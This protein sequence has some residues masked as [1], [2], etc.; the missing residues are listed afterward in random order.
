M[1]KIVIFKFDV[2]ISL[3][4]KSVICFFI[5]LRIIV[6]QNNIQNGINVFYEKSH[7]KY[8]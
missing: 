3:S 8:S 2:F 7:A 4:M 5:I 1:T 6:F